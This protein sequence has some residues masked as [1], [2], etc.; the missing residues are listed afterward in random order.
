MRTEYSRRMNGLP[1]ES[2]ESEGLQSTVI[3]LNRVTYYGAPVVQKFNPSIVHDF[4]C[5]S[6]STDF[7]AKNLCIFYN[8]CVFGHFPIS[9]PELLSKLENYRADSRGKVA[10]NLAHMYALGY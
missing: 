9:V 7:I 6:I 4:G 10:I 1:D 5:K 2:L 3:I 8:S